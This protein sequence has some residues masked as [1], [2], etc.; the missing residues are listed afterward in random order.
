MT[1]YQLKGVLLLPYL[2]LQ[3]WRF[4]SAT[5]MD[6]S[7]LEANRYSRAFSAFAEQNIDNNLLVKQLGLGPN[8]RVMDVGGFDGDWTAAVR[9]R[10]DSRVDVYE[11][12]PAA[13][14]KLSARFGKD[15]KVSIHPVGLASSSR[16]QALSLQGPGSSVIGRDSRRSGRG[17]SVPAKTIDIQLQDVA[18]AFNEL[19]DTDIDLFKINIEGAE[20]EVLARMLDLGLQTRCATLMIQYHEFAPQAHRLR[21]QINQR[22]VATHR[23]AWSYTFVWERWERRN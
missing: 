11:P 22:L 5:A 20:Y 16:E 15:A 1:W 6:K 18:T 21:R 8:S 4:R 19:G 9:K 2:T 17:H 23:P 10:F 3:R 7:I 14:N 12:M 13:V